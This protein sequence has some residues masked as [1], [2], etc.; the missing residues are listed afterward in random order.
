MASVEVP[1]D[2]VAARRRARRAGE[3]ARAADRAARTRW[4]VALNVRGCGPDPRTGRWPRHAWPRLFATREAA[5]EAI[6]GLDPFRA[7]PTLPGR[8]VSCTVERTLLP[9]DFAE[10]RAAYEAERGRRR[11]TG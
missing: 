1:G 11:A 5:L 4:H 2:E 3:A 9:P 7:N 6:E 8:V 10:R